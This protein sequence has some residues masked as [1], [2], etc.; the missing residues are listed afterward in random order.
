MA[1][2]CW[3]QHRQIYSDNSKST[4]LKA[5]VNIFARCFIISFIIKITIPLFIRYTQSDKTADD[6]FIDDF[7]LYIYTNKQ[8]K[9]KKNS[10]LWPIHNKQIKPHGV[11]VHLKY[12]Y[13]QHIQKVYTIRLARSHPY[14]QPNHVRK[15]DMLIKYY[16]Q[17]I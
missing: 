17:R 3:R 4:F 12:I 8:A 2:K 9:Q 16:A 1:L 6:A 14:K 15:T 5:Y 7:S 10:Q 11:H 13:K